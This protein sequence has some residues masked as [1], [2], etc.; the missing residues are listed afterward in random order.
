MKI[1]FNIISTPFLWIG[2]IFQF[3]GVMI[4]GGDPGEYIREMSSVYHNLGFHNHGKEEEDI[5]IQEELSECCGW[6]IRC[7]RCGKCKENC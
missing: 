2:N 3:I 6:P 7:G 4:R 5:E 1:I